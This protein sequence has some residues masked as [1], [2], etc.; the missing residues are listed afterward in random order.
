MDLPL[1]ELSEREK[2]RLAI[3]VLSHSEA[4]RQQIAEFIGIHE[5]TVKRWEDK[6]HSEFNIWDLP[7]PGRE[8][9][10]GIEIEDRFI[11]FYCQTKPFETAG[12]WSFRWA[13]RFLN[14]NNE[15]IGASP[16]RSTMHRMLGRHDLKPH[17]NRYFLQITDPDFFPKMERLI[18]LYKNPPEYLFC[19]DECPGIQILKRLT[20][21]LYPGD[22][23]GMLKWVNE[24]EYIRN[25]TTDLFA[26]LDVNTGAVKANFHA[27]HKKGT[28]LE[29]FRKH[30]ERYPEKARL[31]YIMDN[32]ASHTCYE[33]C[34]AVAELSSI[35]CP[36]EEELATVQLRRK[37][38]QKDNKRII[39]NFTPFHGSW[40]N[41][42]EIVFR[43]VGEKVFKDSYGSPDELHKVTEKYF[44]EWNEN[45][46]HPFTWKYD[47]K[48]LHQKVVQRFTS[49][50]NHS[51]AEITL[52][53][54]TKS[55]LLMI[56]MIEDHWLEVSVD[57]WEK[58]FDIISQINTQL[59][60]AI[61]AST[62]PI[63]SK[64]AKVALD[65]FLQKI[66]EIKS[67]KLAA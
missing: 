2:Q 28:F 66:S 8:R 11:A 22:E 18:Q 36:P 20:P 31:N 42:A 47:G 37:W 51:A 1:D 23:G 21:D 6:N 53:Y 19:F 29:E 24:F 25:G 27:D 52:Q 60:E 13:E 55:S 10:Y 44:K 7:H 48:G 12:R 43:L 35:E 45:W 63:V 67:A 32:L 39:I 57:T 3:A 17:K 59:R 56:N 40:L 5:D 54:L 62:Q 4:E 9:T 26:F 16:S 61:A 30:V 50:L 65:L 38:L 41:M 64:K 46:A 58:L 34:Q 33:F 49:I 15:H 14:M